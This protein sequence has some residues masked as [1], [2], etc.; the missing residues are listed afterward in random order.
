MNCTDSI[1]QKSVFFLTGTIIKKFTHSSILF[2]LT[3]IYYTRLI[4][5]ILDT[6]Q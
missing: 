2:N 3:V 6:L 4:L 5:Q 1:I